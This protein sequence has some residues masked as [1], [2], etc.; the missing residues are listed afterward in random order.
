MR[1]GVEEGLYGEHRLD[2]DT[3]GLNICSHEDTILMIDTRSTLHCTIAY[4]DSTTCMHL[5]C[6]STQLLLD[7]TLLY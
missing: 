3:T 7:Y 1:N 5:H 4:D 6:T 2:T